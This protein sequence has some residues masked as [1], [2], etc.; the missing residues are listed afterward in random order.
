MSQDPG[1][2]DPCFTLF[3]ELQN[4]SLANPDRHVDCRPQSLHQS[5]VDARLG[6]IIECCAMRTW[7]LLVPIIL[8]SL[9]TG[10]WLD[11][12]F[13]RTAAPRPAEPGLPLNDQ[14]SIGMLRNEIPLA[15]SD[16]APA[17]RV[18]KAAWRSERTDTTLA[19][20]R[21]AALE[22]YRTTT[23]KDRQRFSESVVAWAQR[24]PRSAADWA[25]ALPHNDNRSAALKAVFSS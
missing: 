13:F 10:A 5:C 19:D 6:G 25:L 14:T 23:G 17:K 11:R 20:L 18:D 4:D 1:S 9:V 15:E 21:S 2:F 12:S 7:I 3:D 8:T 24:D 16:F 22:A